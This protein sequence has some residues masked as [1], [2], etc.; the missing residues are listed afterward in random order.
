M[1]LVGQDWIIS[2]VQSPRVEFVLLHASVEGELEE[3]TVIILAGVVRKAS[4]G[5]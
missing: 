3:W 1:C 5:G 4:L 2:T